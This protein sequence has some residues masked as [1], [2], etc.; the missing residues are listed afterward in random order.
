MTVGWAPAPGDEALVN[1]LS[2]RGFSTE[3]WLRVERVQPCDDPAWAWLTGRWDDDDSA[4]RVMV[5]LDR[6]LVRRSTVRNSG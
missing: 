2:V 3:R 6:L 4:G 1:G 5:W